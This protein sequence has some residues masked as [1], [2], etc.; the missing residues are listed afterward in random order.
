[1]LILAVLGIYAI[2]QIL[3]QALAPLPMPTPPGPVTEQVVVV[4]RDLAIGT[5]LAADD[6]RTVDMPVEL[7]PRNAFKDKL[8][9]IGR[10]TKVALIDGEMV[11]PHHVA[12]PT[13]VSHD[14]AFIIEDDQVLM[15]FP[16]GDLMS[17]LNVLQRGDLVDILVSIEKATDLLELDQTQTGDAV[18]VTAPQEGEP[19]TRL[20]TFDAMQAVE[21]SAIIADIQYEESRS[22]GPLGADTE[23]ASADPANRQ[24]SSITVKAYLLAISPQDALVLKHLKDLGGE[25]DI[26][27]RS[28]SPPLYFDLD[29]VIDEYIIDKYE[30]EVIK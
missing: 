19:V 2:R 3:N 4:A 16:A 27:L 5:L 20:F 12:N 25:F 13:N 28:A 7:M 26:V 22:L 10:V 8:E 11:L 15:A 18:S 30:L 1:G 6:L 29:P 14:L 23:T 24:P 9:V 17:D 21:I